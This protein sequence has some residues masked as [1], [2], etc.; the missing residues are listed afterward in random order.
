M[1]SLA[2]TLLDIRHR[3]LQIAIVIDGV[4]NRRGD[5]LVSLGKRRHLHLPKQVILQALGFGNV[6]FEVIPVIAALRC[7][8][9]SNTGFV[10]IIPGTVGW[11]FFGDRILACFYH[12]H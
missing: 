5:G 10:H 7:A 11:Q 9:R 12:G 4:D 8:V 3:A 1:D 6:G 2:E